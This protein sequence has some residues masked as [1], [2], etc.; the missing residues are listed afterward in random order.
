[1]ETIRIGGYAPR[2]SVH[3]RAVDHFA[4]RLRAR[5][6]TAVEVDV[7]Y[8]VMDT[9]RPATSLLDMVA[10]GELTWCYFST[11][12]LQDRVPEVGQLEQ[13][14]L[15]ADLG[16]AHAA[17]D[18]SLG[19]ALTS[20]T[21]QRT[22]LEVLG[23]WDNGFRHLT[24]R[25]RPVRRPEDVAGMRVRLQPNPSHAAM[26]EA[27]DG[28]PVPV[29]L[30][31]GIELILAGGV[32]AQENPLANTVAYGVNR[33]HTH[34]TMTGHLYGARG[35][36]ANREALAGMPDEVR[37]AV[38]ASVADAI[39]FQRDAAAR[40]ETQLRHRLEREGLAFVDLEP[41]ERQAFADAVAQ[42]KGVPS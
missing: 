42:P 33:V 14:F 21:Q 2:E 20:A 24:N 35:V 23:Y 39:A 6:G 19:A 30:S 27:W 15:F 5:L 16:E 7:L 37:T 28:V 3:S 9:G 26:V 18:G 25:L 29:E 10:A 4:E 40:Y 13:P 11:S 36:Y 32:D 38:V 34:V 8:N 31:E 22:G 12:Y 41:S 17:L 1:M